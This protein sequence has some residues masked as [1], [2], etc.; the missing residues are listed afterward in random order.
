MI[1]YWRIAIYYISF[2]LEQGFASIAEALLENN[3]LRS[4]FVKLVAHNPVALYVIYDECAYEVVLRYCGSDYIG[5]SF[6]GTNWHV[7]CLFT[8]VATMVV[9]LVHPA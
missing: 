7:L 1:V 9:L 2:F 4:L 5:S 6:S 8:L 3:V